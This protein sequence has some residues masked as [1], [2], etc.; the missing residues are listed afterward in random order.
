MCVNKQQINAGWQWRY[1]ADDSVDAGEKE[2]KIFDMRLIL[3]LIDRVYL[4]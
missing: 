4:I 3:Y 2:M 1:I